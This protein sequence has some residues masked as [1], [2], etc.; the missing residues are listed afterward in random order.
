MNIQIGL[1]VLSTINEK[2]PHVVSS[3]YL[4]VDP[5]VSVGQLEDAFMTKKRLYPNLS[6]RITY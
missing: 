3:I 6:K 2:A 5:C 1:P 4:Y